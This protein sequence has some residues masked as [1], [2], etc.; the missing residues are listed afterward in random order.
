MRGIATHDP[1]FE[2]NL[3]WEMTRMKRKLLWLVLAFALA[4]QGAVPSA[5]TPYAIELKPEQQEAQAAHLTAELLA[6]YHYKAQP[7]NEA[8][9][10]KIFD[11]YLK[12]LDPEKLF[13]IQSDVDRLSVH[14]NRLGDAILKEDL[15]APFAIFN[16]Y[17]QRA[18][19]RFVDAR[20]LLQQGFDFAA[21]ES[22]QYARDKQR[23]VQYQPKWVHYSTLQQ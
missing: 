23:G 19:E 15:S 8:L 12:T 14:R 18:V 17:E 2:R 1:D 4:A 7:L 21:V 3:P 5:A 22:Y 16:V 6:R 10:G 20:A 13:F 9:S 11:Q